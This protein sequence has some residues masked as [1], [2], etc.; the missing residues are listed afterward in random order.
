MNRMRRSGLVARRSGVRIAGA[1]ILA[2]LLLVG[3]GDGPGPTMTPPTLSIPAVSA[4]SEPTDGERALV[5]A[6]VR[7]ARSQDEADLDPVTFA[8]DVALGLGP[9]FVLARTPEELAD[10]ENW[11]LHRAVFRDYVG[12]FSAFEQLRR[13]VDVVMTVGS[14]PHCAGPPMPPPR[15]L[16]DHRRLSI[17][18]A[19]PR[20]CLQWWT[21]DLF[22]NADG[23]VAAITVDFFGP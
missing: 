15:G 17:Q 23:N 1:L 3:C 2:Q 4:A 6:L 18:P 19:A 12:P 8:D 7:F 21:V 14:H 13:D 22:L 16:E 5:E 10:P 11:L 20:S 9:E